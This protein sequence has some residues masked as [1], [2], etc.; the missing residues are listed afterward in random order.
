M[1]KQLRVKHNQASAYHPQSQGALERFHQTLKS[2]LRGY[3]VEMN[4]D[5][6]EGLPWLLLAAR[7]V[8]QESTGFSPNK[9]VFGQTVRGPL[10]LVH[11]PVAKQE[12]PVNLID[13]ING[14]RHRLYAAGELAK[15]KLASAQVK[16]KRLYDRKAEQHQFSPGDRVLA[17]LPMVTSPFQAKFTGPFT[18]LRQVS[19]QNYL[20]STPKRRKSTQLCHV[21]LL[22]PYFERAPPV[23]D[24]SGKEQDRSV[25]SVSVAATVGSAW[26]P[27]MF[28]RA[29]QYYAN[30]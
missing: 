14:F 19:E 20:L 9:L 24:S 29:G 7:E 2:L 30:G 22:K 17:L 23:S 18:V 16:M 11:D 25:R 10:T 27:G 5:W 13:Y 4:Q 12:P 21:N 28:F 15:E 3:C 1:L 26:W 6:E 8:E